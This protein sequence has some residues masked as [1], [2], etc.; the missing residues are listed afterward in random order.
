MNI[1]EIFESHPIVA[2]V[3]VFASTGLAA[4]LIVTAI[5][6]LR[7]KT[8]RRRV[9]EVLFFNELGEICYKEH[10]SQGTQSAPKTF[11]CKNKHCSLRQLEKIT[12]LID[13]A[14]Y[15]IDICIY[16][17]T[18]TDLFLAINRALD[19]GVSIRM[20]SDH[21]M[22]YSSKSK[23]LKLANLGV[24]L[25]GPFTTKSMMHHKFCVIDGVARVQEIMGLKKCKWPRPYESVLISGSVN[26]TY[27]GFVG[28]FENCTITS[29][30]ILA[31]Q[32]QEEFNRMWKAFLVKE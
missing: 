17:F 4:E 6:Y 9:H 14:Q 30:E 29:D 32:F 20:I 11:E 15:S 5:K 13:E 26:W 21:E 27:N 22:A 28:N 23:V 19:R 1:V 25:R 24:P 3:T 16:T 18:C 2:T 12:M 10:Q 8:R 31:C 7:S